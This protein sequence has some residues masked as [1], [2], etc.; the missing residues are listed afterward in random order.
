MFKFPKKLVF[1]VEVTLVEAEFDSSSNV[2]DDVYTDPGAEADS[3]MGSSG[4]S[5]SAPPTM[6]Q[7]Q[8]P[9][10]VYKINSQVQPPRRGSTNWEVWDRASKLPSPFTR[11]DF[12]SV[13]GPA[14]QY[15]NAS[16]KFQI[17]TNFRDL[18]QAQQAY[19]SEFRKRKFI[20]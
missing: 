7:S 6:T 9:G 12:E 8:Y 11:A 19:F 17:S 16:G 4:P 2:D 5:N 15:D 3:D 14:M 13:V 18:R 10:P 20:I 1:N